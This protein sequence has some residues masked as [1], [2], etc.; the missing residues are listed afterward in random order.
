MT[1]YRIFEGPDPIDEKR[2]ENRADAEQAQRGYVMSWTICCIAYGNGVAFLNL[3]S[4]SGVLLVLRK[5]VD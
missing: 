3:T 5:L 2:E 4:L 1:S